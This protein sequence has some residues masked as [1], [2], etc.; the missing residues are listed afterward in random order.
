MPGR[1]QMA[2]SVKEMAV[3]LW[4]C[5]RRPVDAEALACGT[6]LARRRHEQTQRQQPTRALEAVRLWAGCA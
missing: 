4:A 3:R 5:K 1:R 6:R 2:A